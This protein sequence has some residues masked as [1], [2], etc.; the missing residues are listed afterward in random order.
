[1]AIGGDT[2]QGTTLVFG[3][4]SLSLLI[5]QITI[6]EE[7]INM[8]DASTLA[9]TDFQT[10]VKS[11]L[12]VP[13]EVTFQ[14]IYVQTATLHTVGGAPETGTITFPLLGSGSAATYAGTGVFTGRTLP[15]AQIGQLMVVSGK[16][17]FDGDTGPT[18]TKET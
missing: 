3:T 12:K 15:S 14:A 9:T 2:G 7:T 17:K 18:Y 10:L 1:M 4:S 16:F 8:L 5:T 6:G 11:D 13:P